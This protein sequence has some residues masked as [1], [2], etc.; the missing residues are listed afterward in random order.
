MASNTSND[1][2]K[3]GDKYYLCLDGVWFVSDSPE[4]T[5]KVTHE[6]PSSIY[7]IP[8]S[9]PLYYVRYVYVYRLLY[10]G[11][12]WLGAV[13]AQQYTTQ[14]D[15]DVLDA[16]LIMQADAF[17]F[18]GSRQGRWGTV[19][20]RHRFAQADKIPGQGRHADASRSYEVYPMYPI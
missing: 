11:F 19:I 4:G 13:L 6:V 2:I 10:V 20:P 3:V 14:T 9:N 1:V 15:R 17:G 16:V 12:T 5:W 18:K 7:T 8:P